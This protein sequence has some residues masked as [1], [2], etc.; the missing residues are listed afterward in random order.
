MK[1]I[2][3][4]SWK[5]GDN[6][7]GVTSPYL[8]W[9][10]MFGKIRILDYAED[11]DAT[12]DLLVIPGGPDIN[13]A[14]YGEK[15][16]RE[17]GKPCPF[18]EYFDEYILPIY[19]DNFTPIL[20]VCRGHQTLA[21]HF[22]G[23]LHQHIQ[24]ETSVKTRW[25]LVHKIAYKFQGDVKHRVEDVN[26]IHHQVVKNPGDDM[27]VI[28]RHCNVSKDGKISLGVIEGIMHK[29]LPIVGIQAH[30]EELLYNEFANTIVKDLLDGLDNDK[31]LEV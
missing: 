28:A 20:G 11:F 4:V 5:L 21:V 16:H 14:R 18:R 31:Y 30:P 22:N 13:P 12:L 23:S 17:T 3:I 15:P 26:S 24:H 6:S 7:W 27:K 2:G 8:E 1:K 10:D 9:L 25:E 19:V 29:T